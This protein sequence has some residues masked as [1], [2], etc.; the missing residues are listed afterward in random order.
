MVTACLQQ[1]SH[2]QQTK[3][4]AS[5]VDSEQMPTVLQFERLHLCSLWAGLF[6]DDSPNGEC[7]AI[8]NPKDILVL[9]AR[10]HGQRTVLK[11]A[12]YTG[13]H[14]IAG[15]HIPRVL[16]NQLQISFNDPCLLIL[17]IP[18][19]PHTP[20]RLHLPCRLPIFYVLHTH[21]YIH[22]PIL[23]YHLSLSRSP[24]YP[25]FPTFS[26]PFPTHP[27]YAWDPMPLTLTIHPNHPPF[28]PSILY[29]H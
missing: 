23:S 14:A 26:H 10:T 19:Y 28:I 9:S 24:P 20:R 18:I 4:G 11:S 21:S 1:H 2:S 25:Y 17:T 8:E 29:V 6:Q 13:A 12:Q 7:I 27:Y 3:V 16:T 22:L 15:K 5:L